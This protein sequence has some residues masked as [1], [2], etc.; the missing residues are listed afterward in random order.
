MNIFVDFDGTLIDSKLRLYELFKE[1]VKENFFSYD[2]YWQLKKKGI[3]HNQIL[4]EKFNYTNNEI[5]LFQYNWHKRIELKKWLKYDKPF[6]ESLEW[7]QRVRGK[8]NLILVTA[9]QRKDNLIWQ[10]NSFGWQKLFKKI[11]VTEA[12][13]TKE[14]IITENVSITSRDW[15]IGDTGKDIQTAHQ[16]KILSAAVLTGFL[17][18]ETLLMYN[19]TTILEKICDFEINK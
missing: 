4:Y 19:P 3:S 16:L 5:E 2:E 15:L 14:A 9:R 11:L 1:L 6:E 10:L 12:K 13:K 8:A 17:N 18:K 7:L